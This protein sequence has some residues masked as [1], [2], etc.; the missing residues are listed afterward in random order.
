[1]NFT[2]TIKTASKDDKFVGSVMI[3]VN[4]GAKKAFVPAAANNEVKL[5]WRSWSW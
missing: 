1:M 4:D 5:K 3:G 2:G